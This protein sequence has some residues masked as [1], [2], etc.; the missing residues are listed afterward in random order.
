MAALITMVVPDDLRLTTG[1]RELCSERKQRIGI[2][3]P[4]YVCKGDLDTLESRSLWVLMGLPSLTSVEIGL[5]CFT[6]DLKNVTC[7]WQRQDHASS[8]GFFYHSR[9]RCCPR[10]R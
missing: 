8:Q 5:Q 9:P 3:V 2:N 10:N 7:E 4:S 6:R 1:Q